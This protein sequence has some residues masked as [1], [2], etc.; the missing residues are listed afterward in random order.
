MLPNPVQVVLVIKPCL[1]GFQPSDPLWMRCSK[2]GRVN[3]DHPKMQQLAEEFRDAL[4]EE[5]GFMREDGA[6][7]A[8]VYEMLMRLQTPSLRT[9]Q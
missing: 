5:I 3:N 2:C 8:D 1:C 7:D 6:T 4:I 9:V